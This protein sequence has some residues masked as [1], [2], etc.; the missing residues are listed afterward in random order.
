M[1]TGAAGDDIYDGGAGNDT[2]TD[3]VTTSNDTY[4]WGIG[5]GLD[6][7]TDAGGSLDHIDLYT[8]IAKSQLKFVKNANDLEL[9]VL[10]QADKLTI[11]NWYVGTA[12][13]IEEIRLGDGSKVLASEVNGLISAMAAFAP[14]DTTVDQPKTKFIDMPI[15]NPQLPRNAW[16]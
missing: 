7:L 2:F 6:T 4:R 14:M 10:G 15:S 8:G 3:S 1:L 13:Q 16:M 12:N 9:S 11:R 5:S